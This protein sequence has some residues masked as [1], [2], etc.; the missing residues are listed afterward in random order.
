MP[1]YVYEVMTASCEAGEQFEVFQKMDDPP[2][3]HHPETGQPVRRVIA[4][5]NVPGKSGPSSGK[6]V[7]ADRNLERLGFTKYVKTDQGRYEKAVGKGPDR[8]D[9]GRSNTE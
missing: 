9:A 1:I 2:L 3:T 4:C 7:L 6:N 8:L 5:P